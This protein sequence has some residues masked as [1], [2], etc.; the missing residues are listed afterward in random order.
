MTVFWI[1]EIEGS[2]VGVPIANPKYI[3]NKKHIVKFN[4]IILLFYEIIFF[5]RVRFFFKNKNGRWEMGYTESMLYDAR[6]L[7]RILGI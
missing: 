7:K 6:I 1:G 5:F 2:I 4:A 3:R